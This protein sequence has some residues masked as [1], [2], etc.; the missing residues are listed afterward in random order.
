MYVVF[1]L[2]TLLL[3]VAADVAAAA[4]KQSIPGNQIRKVKKYYYNTIHLKESLSYR[5]IGR[6]RCRYG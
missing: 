2:I 6:D 3:F 1:V 5:N 4:V